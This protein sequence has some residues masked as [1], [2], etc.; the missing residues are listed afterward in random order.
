MLKPKESA[1][2][3][4]HKLHLYLL[5]TRADSVCNQPMGSKPSKLSGLVVNN[6]IPG[7]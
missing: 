1:E 4:F 5:K 7:P 2:N 6:P 3:Q